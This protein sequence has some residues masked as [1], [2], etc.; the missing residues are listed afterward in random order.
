VKRPRAAPGSTSEGL[1]VLFE[2]APWLCA[3]PSS[4]IKGLLTVDEVRLVAG[5]PGE[6]ATGLR[7]CDPRAPLAGD[8]RL[9]IG[10]HWYAPWDLGQM[11][12]LAPLA[13]GWLLFQIRHAERDIPLAL[14]VG[15]C[16][17]VH[18]VA[19]VMPLPQ[20][21]FRARTGAVDGA[22]VFDAGASAG[23]RAPIGLKLNPAGLWTARELEQSA[24]LLASAA[25]H[26]ERRRHG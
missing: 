10:S 16:T 25:P 14:R 17:A 23:G 5:V 20:A 3:I 26:P 13:G 18:T 19:E 2:C 21:L 6:R 24:R 4:W 7:R 8:M 11:V 15:P 9:S 1:C 12:E 22:F